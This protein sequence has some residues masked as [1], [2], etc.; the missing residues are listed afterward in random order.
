MSTLVFTF[1]LLELGAALAAS[2]YWLKTQ[3]NSIK[4]FVWYLW[5]IVGIET[6]AMYPYLYDVLDIEFIKL[7]ENSKFKR[8]SW[9]YNI[10]YGPVTV[11]LLGLFMI[12]Q[13]KMKL[14]HIIIKGLTYGFFIFYLSF[15]IIASNFFDS[16]IPYDIVILTF[17]ILI[18]VMLY[19]RELL[20]GNELLNFYKSPV[21]YVIIALILWHISI[22]P[23]FIF[24]DYYR[25]VNS[26]FKAFRNYF[27]NISNIILYSWYI[28]AFLYPLRFKRK[29]VPR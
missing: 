3:D 2:Y 1:H 28:F 22:T 14:S 25:E 5:F 13:T 23:L 16:G 17:I 19:L 4:P 24:N 7:L 9:L 27:L 29:L 20:N 15:F 26:E 11:Y 12:N 18:M 10:F 8:N 6:L 21:F